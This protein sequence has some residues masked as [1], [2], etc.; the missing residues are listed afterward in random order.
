MLKGFHICN[1]SKKY[2]DWRV[3]GKSCVIKLCYLKSFLTKERLIM[4]PHLEINSKG[5]TSEKRYENCDISI[6]GIVCEYENPLNLKYR[7][8]DGNHRM[9]KMK[10]N[11]IYE[12]LFYVIKREEFLDS[13]IYNH[14]LIENQN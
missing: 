3:N 1:N 2:G 7:L 14:F 4:I 5:I 11:Q 8:I 13:L 12:S 10:N 6:P 9:K